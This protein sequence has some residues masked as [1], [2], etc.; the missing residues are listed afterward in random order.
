MT[1][2][3]TYGT[4]DLNEYCKVI[5]LERTQGVSSSNIRS[6]ENKL[7][8]G[9]VGEVKTLELK[10]YYSECAFVNGAEV[11]DVFYEEDDTD[12][13]RYKNFLSEC[14]A[15]YIASHPLLRYSRIKTALENGKHVL[16]KSSFTRN[17]EQCRELFSIAKDTIPQAIIKVIITAV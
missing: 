13:S 7:R 9:F 17:L 16:C 15:V 2:V 4:Y 6:D 5:Y 8:I 1:K 14:D 10:K 11:A 3:I 12:D